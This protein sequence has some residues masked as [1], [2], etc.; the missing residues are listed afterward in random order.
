MARSWNKIFGIGLSKTGT[1]SLAAALRILGLRACDYPHDARTQAQLESGDYDLAV[2]R[3]NDALT[4]TPAAYCFPQLDEQF[5]GSLFIL[6]ERENRQRWLESFREQW[7]HGDEW[8]THDPQFQRFLYF[9][10]CVNYGVTSFHPQR[11]K[12]A[13]ERHSREVRRYFADRPGDLLIHDVTTGSGWAELCKFLDLPL[14]DQPY[15]RANTRQEKA[16]KVE[17]MARLHELYAVVEQIVPAGEEVIFIDDAIVG[18]CR[19]YALR[20]CLP[21]VHEG[22]VYNGPPADS[23]QAIECTE[24]HVAIGRRWL[25][26]L[27]TS[28][29][30]LDTYAE[31]ARYLD[32]QVHADDTCRI[33]R[34][35]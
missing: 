30:W 12:Y 33:Y 21:L 10:R 3:Q 19:I 8:G 15:P 4:D 29:W 35:G 9:M 13:Y 17:L 34:L 25:V 31:W 28:Y 27:Y 24:Q 2:L 5:P 26:V 16:A 14:P 23:A 11:L 22:G 1:T 20:K 7:K 6:T 32:E 18:G